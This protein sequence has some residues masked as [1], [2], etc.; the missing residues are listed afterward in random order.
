MLPAAG[1]GET[2]L[3]LGSGCPELVLTVT[4]PT[5]QSTAACRTHAPGT[6]TIL[7]WDYHPVNI[8]TNIIGYLLAIY[9]P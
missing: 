5:Q 6:G 4:F 3:V 8:I 1:G 9:L 7:W 2:L